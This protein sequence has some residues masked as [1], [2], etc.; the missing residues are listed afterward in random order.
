MC[1]GEVAFMYRYR[2][3]DAFGFTPRSRSTRQS[4]DTNYLIQHGQD[5]AIKGPEDQAV[6]H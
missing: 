2:H 3:H 5:V 4:F 6:E 1:F